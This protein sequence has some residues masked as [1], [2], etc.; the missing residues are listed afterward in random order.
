M[1]EKHEMTLAFFCKTCGLCN[2]NPR[3]IFDHITDNPCRKMVKLS[4]D[5][6]FKRYLLI[7]EK[8]AEFKFVNFFFCFQLTIEFIGY[9]DASQILFLPNSYIWLNNQLDS[10]RLKL[11]EYTKCSH[12]RCLNAR[13]EPMVSCNHCD[14]LVSGLIFCANWAL[15]NNN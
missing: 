9:V 3:H 1:V 14:C 11:V 2:T 12:M 6:I 4:L 15:F 10:A 5:F 7:F 13:A 8:D